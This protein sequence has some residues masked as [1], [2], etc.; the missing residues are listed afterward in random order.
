VPAT[1]REIG[2]RREDLPAVADQ[3]LGVERLIRNNPR[4]EDALAILE[5]AW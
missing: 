2:V 5:A 1:L 3:A 4:P